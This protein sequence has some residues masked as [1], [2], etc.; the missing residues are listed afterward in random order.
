MF[1][2]SSTHHDV[3][4]QGDTKNLTTAYLYTLS[5]SMLSVQRDTE[6]MEIVTVI[7]NGSGTEFRNRYYTDP[8]G[9]LEIP[10]RNIVNS[11]YDI[12]T[13][14][15][16]TINFNELD[17]TLADNSVVI[18]AETLKGISYNDMLAPRQK[19][20]PSVVDEYR[21]D[22]ILPPNVIINPNVA[23]QTMAG[24]VVESNYHTIDDS[25]S[26]EL[27]SNGTGTPVSPLGER[28]AQ[29]YCPAFTDE[30]SLIAGRD[31]PVTVKTWKMEKPD[32]C[33][34]LVVIQWTSL[35]GCLRRHY[36]PIVGYLNEAGEELSVIEAGNGYDIRKNAVKGLRCRL[37]GLTSYGCWYY[38][39][40][41]QASDAHAVVKQ[42]EVNIATE[43]ESME[44]ACHVSG[45]MDTTPQGVGFFNFEFVVKLRRYDTF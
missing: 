5:R 32:V 29:I 3:V 27:V 43:L 12:G 11:F 18:L 1:K 20:S 28:N 24:V 21:H 40:L 23:G 17:G 37:T 2:I 6:T 44:T 19:D 8:K 33:T 45:G 7:A 9:R 26:W 34:D 35:T 30:L 39:D 15:A 36:F 13:S 25:A 16:I 41:L 42:T 38:Q 31:N 10:L 4:V 14:F 22:L